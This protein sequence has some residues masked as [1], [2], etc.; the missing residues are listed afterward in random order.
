MTKSKDRALLIF[1]NTFSNYLLIISQL[2]IF[3]AL[4]P[5]II[6]QLGTVG[7]GLW[8]L[9]LATVSFFELLDLGFSA[10]V[11]KY[12]ADARGKG[13]VERL[14]HLTA[15]FFWVYVGLGSLVL[16]FA[17]S[18]ADPLIGFFGI[19]DNQH[20]SARIVFTTVAFQSAFGLMIG[21]FFGS[22]IGFQRQAW[23]NYIKILEIVAYAVL[24]YALLPRNSTPEMLAYLKVGTFITASIIL[25]I[26]CLTA[27]KGISISPRQF[28]VPLLKEV[29]NFSLYFFLIHVSLQIYLR[30]DAL[31]VQT[32]LSL[33]M[34]ALYS[35][36]SL[37]KEKVGALCHQLNRALSPM[38]AELKGAEEESNIRITFQYGSKLSIAL[39]AP[40]LV[41]LLWYATD[42]LV[43]WV[44]EEFRPAGIVLRILA[45]AEMINVIHASGAHLLSMT[46]HHKFSSL[47][48]FSGQI[49]NLVATIILVQFM[50]LTGVALGTLLA[51]VIVDMLLIHP[52]ARRLHNFS[53]F[54]FYRLALWPSV[55]GIVVMLGTLYLLERW[56][57]PDSLLKLVALGAIGGLV[58]LIGFLLLGLSQHERSYFW[59]RGQRLL[60]KFKK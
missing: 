56:I 40:I 60:Q 13:D 18:I 20:A 24:V 31:I 45:T 11:V 42:L 55:P 6:D 21:M 47:S 8:S 23:T 1:K 7:Y 9:M 59:G 39:A 27:L 5:F 36:A 15:T 17:L 3:V 54:E 48:L 33:S 34:V 30:V 57:P 28:S 37:V 4:T 35:V 52:R 41:G 51:S 49:I 12:V 25:T 10:S 46:G 14:K 32:Y 16:M 58:F 43:V 19:P 44:G 22:I 53:T 2:L 26:L 38:F 50:G 29:V